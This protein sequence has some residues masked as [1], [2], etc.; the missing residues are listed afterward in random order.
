VIQVENL[1]KVFQS[2]EREVVALDGINLSVERGK[3]FGIIGLSGAGKST[4]IRCLNGLEKPTSGRVWVDDEEISALSSIDL[5]RARRNIG[6]VFQLFNL[7]SSR[8]V[9]GNIAFPLEITKVPATKIRERVDE[10]L[11]LV[12]LTDKAN[13]YPAELSGGQK[14]RVGIARAL[15][16][17]PKILL[18]DEATS[19]LDPQTTKSILNLIQDINRTYGLTTI[20]IT[21]EIQ[22]VK[23]ICDSVA[24]LNEGRIVEEG[25][26]VDVFSSPKTAVAREFVKAIFDGEIAYQRPRG[27]Q[28]DPVT[29]RLLRL[30]FVGEIANQPIISTISR[31]YN[32]EFNIISGKIEKV[33][34]TTFGTL[35]LELV[36]DAESLEQACEYLKEHQVQWEE[37]EYVD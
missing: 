3:I 9:R 11:A 16:T 10:L 7:L 28:G 18:C 1:R 32:L 15:A 14:Q 19:A 27:Q 35:T 36:G 31:N 33:Q 5:R 29:G 30:S 8:T 13:A 26:V 12:G 25:P 23:E 6:M 24:I 37:L 17:N 34:S 21:H 2:G 22:V 4:L 20:I